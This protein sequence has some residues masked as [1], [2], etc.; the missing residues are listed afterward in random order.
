[1]DFQNRVA[2]V[3]GGTGALGSAVVLDL[4]EGGA[5]VA[6]PYIVDSEWKELSARAERWRTRLDGWRVD[7]TRPSEVEPWIKSVQSSR[8]RVDYLLTIAGG[9]AAG[10]VYETTESVWDLMMKL[11]LRAVV[12]V[13]RPVLSLMIQQNFGRVVTVGSGAILDQPGAGIAAYAVSKAAVR[14]LS[15]VLAE[16]VK[17]YD[18]RVYCL[19]PGTMDTEAN[20]R[21]MPDADR[22]QWVPTSEVARVIH[23]LL[24]EEVQTPVVVPIVR[25]S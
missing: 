5:Y 15:E 3:T 24:L 22:S 9:F 1:M 8:G 17:D 6:V 23:R 13:L 4:L 16:E 19:M 20:R 18:I 14:Q 7:L 12:G 10:K 11:N 21:A 25:G 2:V